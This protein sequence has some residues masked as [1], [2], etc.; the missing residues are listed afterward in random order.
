MMLPQRKDIAGF[1]IVGLRR[2]I[3][4]Q[5]RTGRASQQQVW[6]IRVDVAG[7]EIQLE[8]TVVVADPSV[9][10]M[11]SLLDVER[12]DAGVNDAAR[13]G[14]AAGV[15]H[16]AP[17]E[18][19][20]DTRIESRLAGTAVREGG[21]ERALAIGRV[22]GATDRCRRDARIGDDRNDAARTRKGLGHE[23][24]GRQPVRPAIVGDARDAGIA[25]EQPARAAA[26]ARPRV[27]AEDA[28]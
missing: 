10:V 15:R 26:A 22:R 8:S 21:A 18:L 23:I 7:E 17:V 14:D 9:A 25:A 1:E 13:S 16:A 27:A 20:V 3:E 19:L 5:W 4:L 24:T 6:R 28:A 11:R 2:K 12:A